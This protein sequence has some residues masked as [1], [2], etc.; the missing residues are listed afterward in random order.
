[1]S[2]RRI[3]VMINR[4]TPDEVNVRATDVNTNRLLLDA[5]VSPAVPRITIEVT[6]DGAQLVI[7]GVRWNISE[8]AEGKL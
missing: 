3:E 1:M 5:W 8:A 4:L 7:E 2:Q 6:K